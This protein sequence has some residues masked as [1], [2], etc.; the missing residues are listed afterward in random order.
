MLFVSII[1]LAVPVIPH[2][3]HANGVICMKH[4]IAP[5]SSCPHHHHHQ[6]NDSCCDSECMTQLNSSVPSIQVDHGPQ[7]ILI[8][9]L[10]DDNLLRNLFD[11]QERQLRDNYAY[12][13]SLHGTNISR[14]FVLRGPPCALVA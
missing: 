10:F 11:P 2:H 14:A 5:E 9:I 3:H 7:H 12:L 4:D 13:E 6:A 8:A 1:M